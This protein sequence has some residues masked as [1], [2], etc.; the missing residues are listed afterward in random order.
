M[1]TKD[2]FKLENQTKLER[3][4]EKLPEDASE[5][6]V[7]AAYDKLGGLITKEGQK[8]KTGCF[9]NPKTKTAIAEPK[10]IYL[11]SVSGRIV[12]VPEGNEL[13]GE[14]RAANILAEEAQKARKSSAKGRKKAEE[15]E[16]SDESGEDE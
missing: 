13:P 5:K 3:A 6:D 11:Y 12:E 2:G 9:Y 7:V 1:V 8:V 4:K 16:E 14:V 10:V 15:V